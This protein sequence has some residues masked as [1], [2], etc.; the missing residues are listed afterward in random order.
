MLEHFDFNKLKYQDLFTKNCY[1]QTGQFCLTNWG[2]RLTNRPSVYPC[3]PAY[4]E[5]AKI[6]VKRLKN[7]KRAGG[8]GALK[9]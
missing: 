9:L 6:H 4:L 8:L 3:L 1:T 7:S 2:R 5:L